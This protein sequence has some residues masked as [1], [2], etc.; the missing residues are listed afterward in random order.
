LDILQIAKAYV[1]AHV[2]MKAFYHNFPAQVM[3]AS[4]IKLYLNGLLHYWSSGTYV[5]HTEE[6]ERPDYNEI[7]SQTCI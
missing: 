5:P 2:S 4:E 7:S 3:E 6:K 1:G